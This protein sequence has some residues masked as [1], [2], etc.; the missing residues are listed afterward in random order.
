MSH[1][2]LRISLDNDDNDLFASQIAQQLLSKWKSFSQRIM[3]AVD[4]GQE[5]G[6]EEKKG[7]RLD[8]HCSR[9]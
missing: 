9:R 7:K 6:V 8:L 3:H 4:D 2:L 1:D 5:E